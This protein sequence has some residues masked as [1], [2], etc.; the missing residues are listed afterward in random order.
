M[1][2][3]SSS[4]STEGAREF[5]IHQHHPRHQR[6]HHHHREQ[7]QQQDHHIIGLSIGTSDHH[8]HQVI[9]WLIDWLTHEKGWD[10]ISS[11]RVICRAI[12]NRDVVACVC[13]WPNKQTKEKGK[14][15]AKSTIILFKYG[16]QKNNMHQKI[17]TDEGIY[18]EGR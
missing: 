7:Q 1:R 13:G 17:L 12:T 3:P 9:E 10:T 2:W 8:H 5:C 18:C 4:S 11:P 15:I 6:H 16:V 14:R